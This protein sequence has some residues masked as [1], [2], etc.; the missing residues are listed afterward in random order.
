MARRP[1]V[2]VVIPT[3]RVG[4]SP[5]RKA[6]GRPRLDSEPTARDEREGL[7]DRVRR[8][9]VQSLRDA[10]RLPALDPEAGLDGEGG[11][12]FCEV[13]AVMGWSESHVRKMYGSK[14][15]PNRARHDDPGS[16]CPFCRRHYIVKCLIDNI[17]IEPGPKLSYSAMEQ[18]FRLDRRKLRLDD[19]DSPIDDYEMWIANLR[20]FRSSSTVAAPDADAA[21]DARFGTKM[22]F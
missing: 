11:R 7:V 2:R 5:Y 19:D 1:L 12:L 13:A 9:L 21:G 15:Y 10:R 22:T 8:M 17:P 14:R 20:R 16:Y 18:V 6:V 4:R 3:P